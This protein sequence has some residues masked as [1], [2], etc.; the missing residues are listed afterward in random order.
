MNNLCKNCGIEA[1]SNYCPD[2]GQS[3]KTKRI[4]WS[5]FLQEF[6]FN[7]FTLH[8]GLLFTIKSLII[9]PKR[10]IEDYLA[11]KRARY[12]GA[13]QFLLFMIIFEILLTF[14]ERKIG[15]ELENTNLNT[16]EWTKN[17]AILYAALSSFGTYLV[18]RKK[19]YNLAEHF[20]LN[21][22]IYGMTMFLG[23][24]I[25]LMTFHNL[26]MMGIMVIILITS[27]YIRIF[28]NDKIRIKDFV[29]GFCCFL[30]SFIPYLLLLTV[31]ASMDISK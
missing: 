29:K 3:T 1:T 31:I 5:F 18:Y 14:I 17:L 26:T 28:Y 22:Y 25:S 8:K 21:F 10:V 23:A 16:S 24:V 6:I 4:E 2:C 19:K 11:G 7:N 12:T 13:I 27:Y 15:Y 30:L 9:N 20:I